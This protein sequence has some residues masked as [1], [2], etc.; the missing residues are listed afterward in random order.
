MISNATSKPRVSAPISVL[1]A[2][3]AVMAVVLLYLMPG[4]AQNADATALLEEKQ[5]DVFTEKTQ[6][7][8]FETNE[9]ALTT[10]ISQTKAADAVFPIIELGQVSP[11][12]LAIETRIEF[13][14]AAK[15]IGMSFDAASLPISANEQELAAVPDTITAYL[16]KFAATASTEDLD[17][18]TTELRSR[19]L[20]MTILSVKA[21]ANLQNGE[22][23]LDLRGPIP[24]EVTGVLWWSSTPALA[25]SDLIDSDTGTGQED[26]ENPA[27]PEQSEI[28]FLV[29]A[30]QTASGL[31]AHIFQ[32]VKARAITDEETGLFSETSINQGVRAAINETSEQAELSQGNGPPIDDLDETGLE[33]DGDPGNQFISFVYMYRITDPGT[34]APIEIGIQ[35]TMS[36]PSYLE[37]EMELELSSIIGNSSD[38]ETL[39]NPDEDPEEPLQGGA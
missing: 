10:L 12:I 28:N 30:E 24:M 19:D 5:Q 9:N 14:E 3:A 20:L 34:Q 6:I 23:G 32:Q 35:V 2:F 37:D 25:L 4:I 29:N 26:I 1:L 33:K 22:T 15:K 18:L 17:K 16:I 13:E 31:A 11:E 8:V 21:Q 7:Q 39:E 38:G 27:A 36:L